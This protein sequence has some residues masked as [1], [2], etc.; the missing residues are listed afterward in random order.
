MKIEK[1]SLENVIFHKYLSKTKLIE[2]LEDID[3]H[4]LLSK[5]EGFPKV[6]LET[7]SMGIPSILYPDY[8]C[9]EWIVDGKDGF[10]VTDVSQAVYVIKKLINNNVFLD[11]VSRQSIR[12]S[13]SFDWKIKI[14]NWEEAFYKLYNL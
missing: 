9:G 12:L 11:S 10:I 6:I 13:K 8:G 14:K 1:K 2:L 3:L 7:A 5:S 4:I